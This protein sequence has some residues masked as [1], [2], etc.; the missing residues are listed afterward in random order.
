VNTVNG[1]VYGLIT[2]NIINGSLTYNSFSGNLDIS[3]PGTW[4]FNGIVKVI[5]TATVE[6]GAHLALGYN[7]AYQNSNIGFDSLIIKPG[8]ILDVSSYDQN[9]VTFA[10]GGHYPGSLT[11][12]RTDGSSL[13][14]INGSL[15]LGAAVNS[16]LSIA[17]NGI[18]GTLTINGNFV[19]AIAGD[20]TDLINFDL[21]NTTN[22]GAGINDLI[23]VN[24]NVDLSKGVA[25]VLINTLQG[26]V[27][28]GKPYTLIAY[29][30]SL[31]GDASGLTAPVFDRAH[32]G[33]IST[34][35]TGAITV[36]FN[37]SGN[38]PANHLLWSGANSQNWDVDTTANW[39][40]GANSDYFYPNDNPFFDDTASRFNVNLAGNILA[41]I[42]TVTNDI[43]AYSFGGGQLAG[44]SSLI[45]QGTSLLTLNGVN[46]Y[47]GGTLVSGGTLALATAAATGSGPVTNNSIL[48]IINPGNQTATIFSNI[49][50]GTG[51]IA[52]PN[53]EAV[54]F[55]GPDC[56][57]HFNGNINIPGGGA[58]W[59]GSGVVTPAAINIFGIG[60]GNAA[61][62]Q[63]DGAT[64]AGPVNL[65]GNSTFGV[66]N[67]LTGIISGN[68][69][70]GGNGYG[71][72]K[73][74]GTGILTLTGTNSYT[75]TTLV[76]NGTVN[77]TGIQSGGGW[78][79]PNN[80]I[81]TTVNFQPGSTVVV[82]DTNTIQAGSWPA[83]GSANETINSYGFVT[84]NGVLFI[85]RAGYLMI[86]SNVWVQNG[87]FTNNP[88]N[89]S[90]YS[91]FT[92]INPAGTFIYNGTDRI[93]L[94]SS[95]GNSG[96]GNFD[97]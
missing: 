36:T 22:A 21:N 39:L 47:S 70:D 45:K 6:P 23:Q 79:L 74:G 9:G 1:G 8:G 48:S 76:T 94:G 12:G 18:P 80:N 11:A 67:G 20:G 27:Q 77:V 66:A 83:V 64:V 7:S 88:P 61:A 2:S 34:A 53:S 41:G 37:A 44:A 4:L 56:L 14:D 95:V 29:N 51:S 25:T 57:S 49:I 33:V 92:Q 54:N 26:T 89:L 87:N 71:V 69:S 50:K 32:R 35:T 3:G 58:F 38:P 86:N 55:I 90:G 85:A 62:L 59:A 60:S 65:Q 16:T 82:T 30:G 42:V 19:P 91:S 28:T 52:L 84:N 43:N 96:N 31:T 46:S 72:T 63:I 24:G 10:V 5:G 97:H 13:T 81:T 17:G 68:I 73:A 75:G 78:S 93:T 15:S 40:N